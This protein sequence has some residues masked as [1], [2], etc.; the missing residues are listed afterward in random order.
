M[1]LVRIKRRLQSAVKRGP[2]SSELDKGKQ[3]VGPDVQKSAWPVSVWQVKNVFG[4]NSG[5]TSKNIGQHQRNL[6]QHW[7]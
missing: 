3:K 4:S 1:F 6:L 2:K 7:G 5:S